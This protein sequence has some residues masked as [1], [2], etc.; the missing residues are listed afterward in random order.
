MDVSGSVPTFLGATRSPPNRP[1]YLT[2]LL[3]SNSQFF[4]GLLVNRHY[5]FDE[6][7]R[8]DKVIETMV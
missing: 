1:G 2:M 4:L 8:T 6:S 3:A 7:K 5:S